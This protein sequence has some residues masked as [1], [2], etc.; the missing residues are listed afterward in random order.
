[1]AELVV[2]QSWVWAFVRITAV[3]GSIPAFDT[4]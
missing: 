3:A 4:N 2:K 1:M